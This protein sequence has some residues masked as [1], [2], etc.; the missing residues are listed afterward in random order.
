MNTPKPH[1]RAALMSGD[2]WLGPAKPGGVGTYLGPG[3]PD[4][5]DKGD[6]NHDNPSHRPRD[7]SGN[8]QGV[9]AARFGEHDTPTATAHESSPLTPLAVH[10]QPGRSPPRGSPRASPRDAV[11][12][13]H[14]HACELV[15]S[16]GEASLNALAL[17]AGY[18]GA[19]PRWDHQPLGETTNCL[20]R[21]LNTPLG[22]CRYNS[23]SA[24]ACAPE[25]G[26]AG[27]S[28]R[29]RYRRAFPT[30]YRLT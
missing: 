11:I 13:S 8:R 6:P 16:R 3:L 15:T 5:P 20:I 22:A 2:V 17:E 4:L 9:A 28:A 26:L 30:R 27:I 14:K 29:T 21:V 25:F 7:E 19:S 1:F 10:P 12:I 18:E 23:G 24:V